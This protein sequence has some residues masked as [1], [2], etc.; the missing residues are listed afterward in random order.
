MSFLD[1]VEKIIRQTGNKIRKIQRSELET[2]RKW[3]IKS[4]AVTVVFV[5]ILWVL[6]LGSSIPKTAYES[7][8]QQQEEDQ[9][10]SFFQTFSA[11]AKVVSDD[12]GSFFSKTSSGV[13]NVWLSIKESL[14]KSRDYSFEEEDV[15]ELFRSTSE[16]VN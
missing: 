12:I 8:Q 7:S 3:V 14:S 2:K 16:D 4:S 10:I 9:D 1:S 11:G 15:R 13:E 6:F 5:V